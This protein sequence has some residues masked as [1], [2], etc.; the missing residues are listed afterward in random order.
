AMNGK[1]DGG[2][3]TE[4]RHSNQER[5]EK[6]KPKQTPQSIA[7]T[8]SRTDFITR[9]RGSWKIA[10]RIGFWAYN[11]IRAWDYEIHRGG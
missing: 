8:H 1:P 9:Q 5:E 6:E 10:N 3:G 4:Q 7:Q 2:D 11:P